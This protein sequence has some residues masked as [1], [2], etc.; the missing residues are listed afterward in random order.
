M[1][2][3]FEVPC[4]ECGRQMSSP[5]TGTN[6]SAPRASGAITRGWD[7]CSRWVSRAPLVI[8]ESPPGQ[9]RPG[10]RQPR[11]HE[12]RA[13]RPALRSGPAGRVRRDR[14]GDRD[15]VRRSG[16]AGPRGDPVRGR[17]PRRRQRSW[18]RTTSRFVSGSAGRSWST[19]HRT[20]T[21]RCWPSSTGGPTSSTSCTPTS[22]S[23][24]SRSPSLRV[25]PTVLTMH[26]RLDLDYLR[27]LLPRYASVPLVSISDDQR[28]AVA[29]LDLTWAATVYN[30]LDFTSYQDV[31]HDSDGYLG[32]VG[33][34]AE[35]KGP[36]AAIEIARRSG[37]PLRMAAKVD[38]LDEDYYEE[39]VEARDGSGRRL[40]R[41]DRGGTTSPPSTPARGPPSSPATGPSRSAW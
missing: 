23:G 7:T 29:D 25:T 30:G 12:D 34:I 27:D 16:G 39:E 20:C 38:P 37:L 11:R 32:F 15:A 1:S 13:G 14:A 3:V 26:G 28:R 18:R 24:R 21:S 10:A 41:G 6:C 22:T 19:S 8:S 9:A 2:T 33:R 36:L 17:R 40:H 35:E 4:P 31:P 5:R